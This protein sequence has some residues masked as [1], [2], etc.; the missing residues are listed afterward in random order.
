MYVTGWRSL[1]RGQRGGGGRGGRQ[2]DA[3]GD[4]QSSARHQA[5]SPPL[6]HIPHQGKETKKYDP[7]PIDL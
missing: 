5:Q 7:G 1:L 6:H 2:G 4:L 3:Q